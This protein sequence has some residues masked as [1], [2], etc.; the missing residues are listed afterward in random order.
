MKQTIRLTES[1]L[2][3]MIQEAVT[4]AL[5]EMDWKTYANAAKKDWENGNE[6]RAERFSA[7]AEDA[8]NRDF[9][10]DEMDD[11][12]K[13]YGRPAHQNVHAANFTPRGTNGVAMSSWNPKLARLHSTY[14]SRE[15]N[16]YTNPISN[17]KP[18]RRTMDAYNRAKGEIQK[19]NNGDYNYQ[20]GKGWK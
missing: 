6:E 3:N 20:K 14:N 17:M 5:N 18:S 10:Y 9:E 2:R 7:A 13:Y 8:F 12:L 15:G 4:S 16:D 1:T 19:Y 11:E